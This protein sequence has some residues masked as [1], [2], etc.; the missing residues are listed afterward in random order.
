MGLAAVP[1]ETR[2]THHGQPLAVVD[3]MRVVPAASEVQSD[4]IEDGLVQAGLR[5]WEELLIG[6]R[7][8]LCV[9]CVRPG[10]EQPAQGRGH[11]PALV[12]GH[13]VRDNQVAFSAEFFEVSVGE[14]GWHR[15]CARSSP[16]C[17]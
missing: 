3:V 9:F 15:V 12:W 7:C 13:E 16:V 5:V 14:L 17:S 8:G 2:I 11:F 10:L 1:F 4:R 6:M